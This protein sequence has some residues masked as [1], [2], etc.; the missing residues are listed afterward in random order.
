M[1]VLKLKPGR[2]VGE[3]KK[4]IEEAILEG[5]IANDYNEAYK[6]MKEIKLT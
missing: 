5:K 4:A 2:Q 1:K 3:I 6:F